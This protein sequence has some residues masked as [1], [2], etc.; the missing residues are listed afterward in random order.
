MLCLFLLLHHAHYFLAL[1]IPKAKPTKAAI[2]AVI[3]K[4]A[5]WKALVEALQIEDAMQKVQSMEDKIDALMLALDP[6]VR[7]S[8][9]KVKSGM[10]ILY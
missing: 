3:V 10:F 6:R 7:V 5:R 9:V 4:L 2:K 8:S 1:F